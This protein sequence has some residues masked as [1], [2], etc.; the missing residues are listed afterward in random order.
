[1]GWIYRENIEYVPQGGKRSTVLCIYPPI[2]A[3]N[4][5]VIFTRI[6][7]EDKR[8]ACV[9]LLACA[10]CWCPICEGKLIREEEQAIRDAQNRFRHARQFSHLRHDPLIF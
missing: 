3:L 10:G 9:V 4:L 6:D 8:L 7:R 1:M 2:K 5:Q